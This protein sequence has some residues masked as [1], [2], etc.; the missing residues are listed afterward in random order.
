MANRSRL[1]W[2]GYQQR[3]RWRRCEHLRQQGRPLMFL[4]SCRIREEAGKEQGSGRSKKGERRG[5][6]EE[7]N[8]IKGKKGYETETASWT[9]E[10]TVAVINVFGGSSL[11]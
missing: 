1:G 5:G 7:A 9:W 10:S 4:S 8:K 2:T 11:V 3:S 6:N